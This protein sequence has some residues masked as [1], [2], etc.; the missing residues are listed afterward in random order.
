MG[1]KEKKHEK[2]EEMMEGEC[3]CHSDESDCCCDDSC[4]CD[5]FTPP[6]L[7]RQFYTKAEKIE[8][9]EEYLV[10]LKAETAAVEEEIA[11]LKK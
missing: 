2:E 10:D 4:C 9:L 8:M 7:T 6:H 3:C 11:E 5:E 1:K